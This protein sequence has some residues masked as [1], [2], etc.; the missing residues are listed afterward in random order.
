MGHKH[1]DTPKSENVYIKLLNKVRFRRARS[2]SP[3]PQGHL[4][5]RPGAGAGAGAQRGAALVLPGRVRT[6]WRPRLEASVAR[7]ARGTRSWPR[8]RA[9][10]KGSTALAACPPAAPAARG[11]GAAVRPLRRP[12][13]PA[14]PPR[15]ALTAPPPPSPSPPSCCASSSLSQLYAFLARR[16]DSGFNAVVHK[17]L[18]MSRVNRPPTGLA[19][20]MRYMEGKESKVAVLVGTVTDD[21]RLDGH[22]VPALKVCALRFTD[23]ARAR[24]EKNGGKCLTFDQLALMAPKGKDTVLLRG[25]KSARKANR[26]FGAAGLP[27]STT[28]P[29]L[30]SKGRKF[31]KARGRRA[32]RGFAN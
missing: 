5:A 18:M 21:I 6:R 4:R 32:S 30:R 12:A 20:L 23:K 26:Y 15:G 1:R 16:T 28:R 22:A 19:R 24:I 10:P 14:A 25:R 27:G 9:L 7:A 3:P 29:K 11:L 2:F 8:A 17:R 31:E 13:G